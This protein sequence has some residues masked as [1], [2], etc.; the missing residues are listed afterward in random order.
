MTQTAVNYGR[1]LYELGISKEAVNESRRILKEVPQLKKA[2]AGPVVME[3]TK[4]EII[5][6]IFPWEMVNFL[7]VA[8][9]NHQAGQLEEML[10]G[11]EDYAY[12]TEHI[13]KASL[14][15]VT[16]PSG[17]QIEKIKEVLQRKYAKQD[18]RL[19][20]KQDSSLIGGFI[21]Q[22]EGRETDRSLRGRLERLRRLEAET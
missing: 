21:L 6:K 15:Y 2:L 18:I 16:P 3:K 7:K 13:L 10:E 17:D 19:T 20:L 14:A 11:Y 9:K 12:K 4:F 1:V 22:A 8:C 5:E